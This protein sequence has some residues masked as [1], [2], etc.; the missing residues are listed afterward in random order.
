MNDLKPTKIASFPLSVGER[1]SAEVCEHFA[2]SVQR[3]VVAGSVRRRCKEVHDLDIIAIPRFSTAPPRTLFGGPEQIS[4]VDR[5]LDK[6]IGD[7]K[8][9]MMQ[10]GEKAIRFCLRSHPI[11]VDFYLASQETW[12]TLLLI[13][14]GSRDHNIFL[15]SR[16]RALGM[17]L[18]ADGS[19]LF[20]GDQL[21]ASDSE[22]SIFRELGL[23]FS[24]PEGRHSSPELRSR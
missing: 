19:G 11:T 3:I 23:D 12:A 24:P 8:I 15:C 13:R 7:G 9:D 2:G 17:H 5:A 22:Q 20:R 1:L 4:E 10:R 18:K 21:I 14:T 16:A 6:L